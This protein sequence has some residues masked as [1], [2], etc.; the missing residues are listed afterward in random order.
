M[1][2]LNYD[3]MSLDELRRY[4]LN[5]RED[6]NAFYAYIERSKATGRMITIDTNDQEWEDKLTHQIEKVT[7]S[8][9]DQD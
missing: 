7:S 9:S 6:L 1:T 5:Y 2:T 4:V 3:E 8:K